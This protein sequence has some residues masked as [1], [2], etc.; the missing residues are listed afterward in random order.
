M[1]NRSVHHAISSELVSFNNLAK[2]SFIEEIVIY[3]YINL[4]TY[5]SLRMTPKA[6]Q[7]FNYYLSMTKF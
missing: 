1:F 7:L 2:F 3:S 5:N 6:V 4:W